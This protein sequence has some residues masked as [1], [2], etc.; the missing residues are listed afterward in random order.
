MFLCI[1]YCS[2]LLAELYGR[3]YFGTGVKNGNGYIIKTS[4]TM[5]EI[6]YEV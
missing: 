2:W 4:Q 5:E 3:W 6:Y 1:I